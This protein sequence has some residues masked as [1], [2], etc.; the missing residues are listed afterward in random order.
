M[1]LMMLIA[2]CDRGYWMAGWTLLHWASCLMGDS[3]NSRLE[4]SVRNGVT[5]GLWQYG[6]EVLK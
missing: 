2:L 5:G 3:D 6:K 1:R 4:A